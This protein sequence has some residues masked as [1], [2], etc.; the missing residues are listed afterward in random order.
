MNT[1]SSLAGGTCTFNYCPNISKPAL[2]Y[3]LPIV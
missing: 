3:T 1:C 2:V